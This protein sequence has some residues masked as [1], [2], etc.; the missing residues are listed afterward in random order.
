MTTATSFTRLPEQVVDEITR[1]LQLRRARVAGA[2][3]ESIQRAAPRDSGR[4]AASFEVFAD[5]PSHGFSGTSTPLEQSREEAVRTLEEIPLDRV[6]GIA[7]AAPYARRVGFHGHS[8]QVPRTWL[9]V[10]IRTGVTSA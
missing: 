5:S 6:A 2:V 9:P 1:E 3:L 4:F 8:R 10:A 7:T